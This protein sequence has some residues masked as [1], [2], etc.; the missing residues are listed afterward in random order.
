MDRV[1]LNELAEKERSSW[2]GVRV[3]CC[4]ASGCMAADSSNVEKSL[5]QTVADR[6]LGDRVQVVSVGCLGLCG[7]GPLVEIV[8]DSLRE[9]PAN[10]GALGPRSNVGDSLRESPANRGA[11]GPP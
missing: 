9:S 10:R 7:R 3:H 5:R 1:E 2:K 4:T 6:K 8:G 11:L